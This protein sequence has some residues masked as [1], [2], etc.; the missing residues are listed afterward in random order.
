MREGSLIRQSAA[1]FLL[2]FP[3][4]LQAQDLPAPASPVEA[5]ATAKSSQELARELAQELA[6]DA[7]QCGT[8]GQSNESLANESL[9]NENLAPVAVPFEKTGVV[10]TLPA[11]PAGNA[12]T[13][14]Q[15]SAPPLPPRPLAPDIFG[16]SAVP[17]GL[18][19]ASKEGEAWKKVGNAR[20]QGQ[21]GPWT[22][23]LDQPNLPTA[24]NLLIIVNS[25]VNWHVRYSPDKAPNDWNQP[26]TTLLTGSGDCADYAIAKMALLQQLGV[27]AENMFLIVLRDESRSIDHAVLAVRQNGTMYVLDNQ[28]DMV[29]PAERLH[30]YRPILSYNGP[31]AWV[32]G[33]RISQRKGTA[34]RL[35]RPDIQN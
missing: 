4:T 13:P 9:A 6:A 21:T 28:T 12:L 18:K 23:L 29:L 16:L 11:E 25:W 22:E 10:F 30:D 17:V 14:C 34:E 31:F 35:E 8:P 26:A 24:D 32:Y 27:S 5:A 19:F 2:V 15:P 7:G 20:L 1:L 33:S 3:Y